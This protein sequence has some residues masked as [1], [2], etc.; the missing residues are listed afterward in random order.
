MRNVFPHGCNQSH[1]GYGKLQ[2]K[3]GFLI[4]L[5]KQWGRFKNLE[6]SINQMQCVNLVWILKQKEI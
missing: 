5:Q 2:D 1:T 3:Q 6:R 4:K